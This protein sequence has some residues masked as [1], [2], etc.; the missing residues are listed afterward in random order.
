MHLVKALAK[1]VMR[2]DLPWT[3]LLTPSNIQLGS[4]TLL[5]GHL[6]IT[7]M[8]WQMPGHLHQPLGHKPC[9]QHSW[10]EQRAVDPLFPANPL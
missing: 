9:I 5:L 4:I 7:L 6:V 3:V 2:L 8:Q 10:T 1:Q